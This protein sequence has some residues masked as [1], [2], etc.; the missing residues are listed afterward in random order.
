MAMV[1]PAIIGKIGVVKAIVLSAVLMST[2]AFT[3]II[4]GWRGTL[5]VAE[6]A[7]QHGSVWKFFDSTTTAKVIL[8]VGNVLTGCGQGIIWVAQG[9][10]V[11]MCATEETK[12]FYYA[13]YWGLYM[14]SNILGSLVGSIMIK[15]SSGPSFFITLGC[16]MLVVAGFQ[17]RIRLPELTGVRASRS[18]HA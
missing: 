2:F 6:K 9:E 13:L 14:M 11:G 4:T 8:V 12:S 15:L 16:I 7:E 10:F 18:S 3:L 17:S 5:T 1:S